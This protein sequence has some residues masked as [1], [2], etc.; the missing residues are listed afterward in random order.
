SAA[1]AHVG[2][3]ERPRPDLVARR[4]VD[5]LRL[6][7]RR[8][9]GHLEGPLRRRRRRPRDARRRDRGA[10]GAARH[11]PVLR[12]GRHVGHLAP[13]RGRRRG[14]PRRAG[15]P[16][17][18]LGQLGRRRRRDLLRPSR[19]A[20]P[21]ARLPRLRHR[22]RHDAHPPRTPPPPPRPLR[23]TRRPRGLLHPHRPHRRRHPP[24][25]RLRVS[26]I[27]L[28]RAALARH[29]GTDRV[30]AARSL[31]SLLYGLRP[32]ARSPAAR[33]G[34][35]LASVSSH[36]SERS[37]L[38]RLSGER[39]KGRRP[40]HSERSERTKGRRPYTISGPGCSPEAR[41]A[42][43]DGPHSY[44]KVPVSS[45]RAR[46]W[47]AMASKISVPAWPASGARRVRRAW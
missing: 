43:G 40:Y 46:T 6:E 35:V 14:G 23:L 8:W 20:G 2:A 21:R 9:V 12:A 47:P 3:V 37:S 7:P 22:R 32:F 13:A 18:R 25:R 27:L 16:S 29:R 4:G 15:P 39:T 26:P 31:R 28:R 33:F 24:R 17:L 30:P 41:H 36:K 10:G 11:R 44:P 38:P 34:R 5:L 1:P 42:P 19:R 45:P